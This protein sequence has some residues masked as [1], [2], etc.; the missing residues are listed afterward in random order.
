MT[1]Q[2]AWDW[3]YKV[4]NKCPLCGAEGDTLFHR[5]YRC[6]ATCEAVKAVVP[7][8]FRDEVTGEEVDK[9]YRFWTSA[10]FPNP[11]D[12]APPPVDGFHYVVA[13]PEEEGYNA[14][15]FGGHLHIDGP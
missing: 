5:V 9:D 2:R 4:A 6:P 3:G 12:V 8:W 13:D 1:M 14:D 10:I 11:L 15:D 7:G